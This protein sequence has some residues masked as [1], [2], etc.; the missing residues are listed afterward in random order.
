MSNSSIG[1]HNLFHNQRLLR[2]VSLEHQSKLNSFGIVANSLFKAARRSSS[3]YRND[4]KLR[5]SKSG[6]GG[7]RRS[8]IFTP[9]AVLSMEPSFEQLAGKFNLDGNI[10]MQVFVSN[11]LAASVAQINIQVTYSSDSLLLHWGAI[12]DVKEKWVLPS[13]RPNGTKN[14]KNRALRSPFMKGKSEKKKKNE[15][16]SLSFGRKCCADLND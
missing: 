2:P 16:L 8:V 1:H 13:R 12:R 14:Y 11:S 15:I 7:S 9:R 4:L 5:R 10:Q 6:I 3:F